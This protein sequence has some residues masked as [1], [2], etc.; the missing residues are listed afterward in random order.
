M[1]FCRL[2]L[3][4]RSKDRL[5]RDYAQDNIYLTSL[6]GYELGRERS[7]VSASA[8]RRRKARNG[9]NAARKI[10]SIRF[11]ARSALHRNVEC[12][13]APGLSRSRKMRA[14]NCG[15]RERDTGEREEILARYIVG[16]DSARSW[17]ADAWH[18]HA[19][20][21]AL[22]HTTTSSFAA[23]PAVAARQGKAYRHIF[24]GPKHWSTIVAINGRDEWRFSI[25]GGSE[26]REY[27]HDEIGAL[28][29]RAV[30]RD[31]EFE[32]LS[33]LPWTR[34]ELVA[35]AIAMAVLNP[36]DAVHVCHRRRLRQ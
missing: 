14:G 19:G 13:T 32:I 28:I 6:T 3:F 30:G 36:G 9:E 12:V 16:C 10:C 8:P 11:C 2:G 17:C 23:P 24:I 26:Q 20:Q 25:I 5:I 15:D 33:V 35:T 34:R 18:R 1:E 4:R 22:T 27:S 7:P 31:F 21:S 29:R